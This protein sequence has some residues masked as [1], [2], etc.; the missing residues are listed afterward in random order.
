MTKIILVLSVVLTLFLN[1]CLSQVKKN[2]QSK[3]AIADSLSG[4]NL[5]SENI[6]YIVAKNY[7]LKNTVKVNH[8]KNPKIESKK[9]FDEYFGTAPLMGKEGKPTAIDFAKQY[10]IAVIIGDVEFETKIMPV[11]LQKDN[12]K[13]ITFTY[14]IVKGEK[15][16]YV[17]SPILIIVV[18]KINNGTVTLKQKE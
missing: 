16:S 8:L 6:L 12:K 10:V 3:T 5:K 17:I 2:N 7:Y 14:R 18:D 13:N 9:G 1:P 4:N 15:I 11:S